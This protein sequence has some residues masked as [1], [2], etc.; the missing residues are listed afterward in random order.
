MT[1]LDNAS[2]ICFA[3][4]GACR[5]TNAEKL[6]LKQEGVTFK[7]EKLGDWEITCRKLGTP[8]WYVWSME[9]NAWWK[10]A[11]GGYTQ[12]KKEA[13]IYSYEEAM[14]IVREANEHRGEKPPNEAMIFANEL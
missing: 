13:G 6:I 8:E 2:S 3:L 12:D 11:W 1:L 14:K 7:D 10:A 5:E 9:H 4:I